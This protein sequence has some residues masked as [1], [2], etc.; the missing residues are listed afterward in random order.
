MYLPYSLVVRM[1]RSH[2]PGRGSIPRG[3]TFWFFEICFMF[4]KGE[5][6]IFG[7][8]VFAPQK[9]LASLL[10]VFSFQFAIFPNLNLIGYSGG[11]SQH[12]AEG[13]LWRA[14]AIGADATM[15]GFRGLV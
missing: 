6:A 4:F 14:A 1:G 11:R 10:V 7:A 15:D 12:A 9:L 2:R 3:G 8:R 5:T 13:I